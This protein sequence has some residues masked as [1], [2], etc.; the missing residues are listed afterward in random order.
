MLS[1]ITVTT[2][3]AKF[4]GSTWGPPGSCRPQMGPMSAPWTLLSGIQFVWCYMEFRSFHL[5]L[6]SVILLF[7]KYLSTD[8][9]ELLQSFTKALTV[10]FIEKAF[11]E[12]HYSMG[13]QRP[14]YADQIYVGASF[15]GKIFNYIYHI[16]IWEW[17]EMQIT[18]IFTI[19]VT[20]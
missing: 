17:H 15:R 16:N 11:T 20:S 14:W 4:M 10:I 5:Y 18:Y 6:L 19:A 13:H 3:I 12:R 7:K 8:S 9:M 1:N 2:Q